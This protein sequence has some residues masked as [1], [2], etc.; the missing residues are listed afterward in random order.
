MKTSEQ[1]A[2]NISRQ[3]EETQEALA[4]ERDRADALTAHVEWLKQELRRCASLL[5]CNFPSTD[6]DKAHKDAVALLKDKPETSLARLKAKWQAEVL[7]EFTHGS[8]VMPA[9]LNLAMRKRADDLYLQ[10]VC[11]GPG[12]CDDPGCPTHYA[13]LIGDAK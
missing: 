13:G 3:Y 2:A 1:T 12:K 4:A 5:H 8:Y 6:K 11:P 9:T 10:D 7:Y